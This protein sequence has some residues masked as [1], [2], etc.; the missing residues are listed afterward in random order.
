MSSSL[1]IILLVVVWLLVLLP[2]VVNTKEPIRRTSAAFSATRVLHRGDDQQLKPRRRIFPRPMNDDETDSAEAATVET[3]TEETPAPAEKSRRRSARKHAK[4]LTVDPAV[5]SAD[6]TTRNDTVE[7]SERTSTMAAKTSPEVIQA[8][9]PFADDVFGPD[10]R[11]VV[12]DAPTEEIIITPELLQE[13]LDNYEAELDTAHVMDAEIVPD[14]A[15]TETLEAETASESVADT[16]PVE[17]AVEADATPVDSTVTEDTDATEMD[18]ETEEVSADDEIEDTEEVEDAEDGVDGMVDDHEE[19]RED[20]LDASADFDADVDPDV[21]IAETEFV[22]DNTDDADAAATGTSPV[23]R[24]S[25]TLAAKISGFTKKDRNIPEPAPQ[26]TLTA[27]DIAEAERRRGR[28]GYDPVAAEAA[29]QKRYKRRRVIF[30]VLAV[31]LIPMIA[32]AAVLGGL[33]WIAPAAWCGVIAF[34]LAA[35]R[36]QV[37]LEKEL[38]QRRLAQMRRARAQRAEYGYREEEETPAPSFHGQYS[39]V[40]VDDGDPLFDHLETRPFMEEYMATHAEE[41]SYDDGGYL[42]DRFG[43]VRINASRYP[44][45]AVR[46]EPDYAYDEAEAAYQYDDPYAVGDY[47]G[48]RSVDYWNACEA[49]DNVVRFDLSRRGGYRDVG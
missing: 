20:D 42:R 26:L 41:F 11:A 4:R 12:S 8:T 2:M 15:A 28:G 14:A 5:I 9:L 36:S 47:T 46:R 35:L 21:D 45:A 34:Y 32:A 24:L 31:L 43:R 39:L 40:D 49:A 37:R 13:S 25:G 10:A 48:G 27:D 3:A 44:D 30:L 17:V 7:S 1:L 6:S 22:A 38:R 29:A 33:V 16:D 23:S 18:A 19:E